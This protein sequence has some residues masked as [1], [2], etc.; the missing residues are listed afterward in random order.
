MSR[1]LRGI[2]LLAM[3]M[4]AVVAALVVAKLLGPQGGIDVGRPFATS[5][6]RSTLPVTS[7]TI[8]HHLLDR[9]GPGMQLYPQR[10]QAGSP[11]ELLVRG[12]GCA[13]GSGVV[14][15]TRLGSAR[16]TTD[17][18]RL[19][20]RRRIDIAADGSWATRPLLVG[21]P[22]GSYR[23]T[24]G[25][26][27]RA[28]ADDIEPLTDR[29][30]LFTATEMLELTGP[31]VV[32]DFAVTPPF[33]P[34]GEGITVQVSGSQRCPPSA[35]GAPSTVS[36]MFVPNAGATGPERS[37]TATVDQN[38][39]WRTTVTLAPADAEGSYSVTATCSAGF[40]FA[41]QSLRFLDTSKLVVPPIFPWSGPPP[42]QPSAPTPVPGR[43]TYT[44]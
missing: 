19:V 11:L 3:L 40:A 33:A 13:G 37:F 25:C 17:V 16:D 21:Q 23:V 6:T 24:A 30:D 28:A 9:N 39:N 29:R 43:P 5:T 26:E 20:V 4:L 1:G 38:G 42:G 22:P 10:A 12:D 2:L 15:I 7:T 35:P 34:P 31:A 14:S 18:D 8:S 36:G 27:R 41:T 32:D 44:G